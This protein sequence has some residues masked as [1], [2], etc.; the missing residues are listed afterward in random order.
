MHEAKTCPRC[1]QA[2]ECKP[3]NIT[4]CQCFGLALTEKESGFIAERY[5]DCLCR[6]CL[7]QLKNQVEFFK[8]KFITK[9]K[10]S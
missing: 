8:E 2:F 5:N 1:G 7:V 6:D 9:P 3:G 4:Q 10:S